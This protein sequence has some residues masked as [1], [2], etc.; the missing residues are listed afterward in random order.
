MPLNRPQIF[1][2]RLCGKEVQLRKGIVRSRRLSCH[3][4]VPPRCNRDCI[5]A[6]RYPYRHQWDTA[7]N[8]LVLTASA[9]RSVDFFL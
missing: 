5:F 6:I 1:W 7:A 8:L 2:G 4:P 3:C 9:T